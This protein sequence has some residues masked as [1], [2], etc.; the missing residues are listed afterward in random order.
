M[1]RFS[2]LFMPLFFLVFFFQSPLYFIYFNELDAGLW[3]QTGEGPGVR[4]GY[5]LAVV[6]INVIR[7]FLSGI[8]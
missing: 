2:L 7:V 5:C 6:E 8:Y 4:S 1:L 3:P